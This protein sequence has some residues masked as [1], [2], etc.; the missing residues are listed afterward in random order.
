[1]VDK[2]FG[3]SDKVSALLRKYQPNAIL[4]QGPLSENNLI[5]WVGNEEGHAPYPNWSKADANTS[6]TG[7]VEIP[8]LNGNPDGKYWIPGETDFPNRKNGGWMWKANEEEQPPFSANE[9]LDRY[10]TSVGRN[11][12]MLIGMAIDTSGLFPQHDSQIFIDFGKK[13]ND[14]ANS[15]IG[16]NHG[17][18]NILTIKLSSA[19][20]INQLEIQEDISKGERIRS[21]SIEALVEGNWHKLC[22]GISIGHKRIQLIDK[23]NVTEL[24]LTI[25]KSEGE[26]IIKKFSAYNY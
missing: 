23:V 22:D 14:R 4:F 25:T 3:I 7:A 8:N 18:G 26:P 2:K 1:M 21:Y 9:L 13:L 5:R 20:E 6:A 19:R 16:T 15:L 10:Y 17:K 12:N 24:K 11:A